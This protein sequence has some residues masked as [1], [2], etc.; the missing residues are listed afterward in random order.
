MIHMPE[1]KVSDCRDSKAFRELPEHS[2]NLVTL[3]GTAGPELPTGQS[4]DTR[5]SAA[6]NQLHEESVHFVGRLIDVLEK[7]DLSAGVESILR[8]AECRKKRKVPA[9]EFALHDSWYEELRLGVARAGR[10]SPGR[11]ARE[12]GASQAQEGF[13]WMPRSRMRRVEG[14]GAPPSIP[15]MNCRIVAEPEEGNGITL[16]TIQREVI[17]NPDRAVAAAE[18]PD[19]IEGTIVKC[20]LKVPKAIAVG[21]GEIPRPL[22]GGGCH[23]R[24]EPKGAAEVYGCLD[25]LLCDRARR[26]YECNARTRSQ[27]TWKPGAGGRVHRR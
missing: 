16:L 24:I 17:E 23:N 18:S 25:T 11:I 4:S 21:A 13:R 3:A 19:A 8:T 6:P 5:E 1:W 26:S 27:G 7:E 12:E 9:D 10:E 22:P 20:A 14:Y 15:K 2:T